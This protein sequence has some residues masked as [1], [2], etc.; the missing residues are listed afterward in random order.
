MESK[1]LLFDAN[2]VKVGETFMR[3]AR[4]LVNQQRAQWTDDSHSAI[5]F[6]PDVNEWEKDVEPSAKTTTDSKDDSWIYSLAEKR[7]H[8]RKMF[9]LHTVGLVPG[10][11]GLFV[12]FSGIIDIWYG[13][14]VEGG[15]WFSCGAWTMA[16]AIHAYFFAKKYLKN[17]NSLDREERRIH[18]I[19]EEVERLKRMGYV[20][21]V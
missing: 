14:S 20:D 6:V 3:R 18:R 21:K 15:F 12:V 1:V 4:Q 2:D 11:F 10:Y 17:Y 9:I 13:S 16:Y 7:L 5:R 19:T 8:E